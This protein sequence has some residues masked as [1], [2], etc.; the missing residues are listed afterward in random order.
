MDRHHKPSSERVSARVINLE[1]QWVHWCLLA[2]G[3][4]L[5]AL[6]LCSIHLITTG[7]IL[8]TME[9]VHKPRID[10]IE[11]LE[12]FKTGLA[13]RDIDANLAI[14]PDPETDYAQSP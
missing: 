7:L 2:A 12:P 10:R 8:Q 1:P 5:F 14:T 6:V 4:S 11:A 13:G 3:S 9:P